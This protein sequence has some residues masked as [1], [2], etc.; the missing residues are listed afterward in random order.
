MSE[1]KILWA[2][3]TPKKLEVKKP[4]PKKPGAK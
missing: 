4:I 3:V 1:N 2:G